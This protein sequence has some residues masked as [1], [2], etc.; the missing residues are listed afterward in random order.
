MTSLRSA[1]P[2]RPAFRR[3]KTS[4]SR[5]SRAARAA[6]AWICSA[7]ARTAGLS[8][9]ASATSPA[10]PTMAPSRLLKSWASP[11]VSWPTVSIRALRCSLATIA[12]CA[13]SARMRAVM[14]LA[15][16][17]AVTT[18]PSA[19]LTGEAEIDMSRSAPSRR[20]CLVW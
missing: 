16:M 12:R 19:F 14:S 7:S 18:T 5:V 17:T 6:A 9:V 4:S 15:T 8:A 20:T 11:P 13:A 2:G 3:L 1:A 10:K